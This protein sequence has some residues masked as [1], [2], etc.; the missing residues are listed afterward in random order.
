VI[1]RLRANVGMAII[2]LHIAPAAVWILICSD[3]CNGIGRLFLQCTD[4][5]YL[6]G[7]V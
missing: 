6:D 5:T 7:T 2:H 4:M 1:Q 3:E